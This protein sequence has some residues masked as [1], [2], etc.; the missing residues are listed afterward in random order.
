MNYKKLVGILILISALSIGCTGDYGKINSTSESDSRVTQQ[1]LIDNWSDY[2]I[3]FK[4]SII[5][6]D[7][8]N[9]DKKILVGSHWGTVKD[10]ETWKRFV[11]ENTDNGSDI[12]PWLAPHPITGVRE[13]WSPDNQLYGYSIYQ[14]KDSIFTEVIDE[15]TMRLYHIIGHYGGP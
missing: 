13:I 14:R 6:F 2:D 15:N 5:V 10:Q 9:D 3:R 1:K 8:V 4:E 7:P 11:K 12:S